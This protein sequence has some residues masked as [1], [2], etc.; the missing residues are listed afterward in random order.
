MA[1]W[2]PAWVTRLI[3]SPDSDSGS[4]KGFG[5]F[6]ILS[7]AP[8]LTCLSSFALFSWLPPPPCLPIFVA[9]CFSPQTT[10][11]ISNYYSFF[12]GLKTTQPTLI[13]WVVSFLES[14]F[15]LFIPARK[16]FPNLIR[17]DYRVGLVPWFGFDDLSF[18]NLAFPYLTQGQGSLRPHEFTGGLAGGTIPKGIFPKTQFM[19]PSH[20]VHS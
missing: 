13:K 18:N 5:D 17:D 12:E 6:P 2:L 19:A 1:P 3:P 7:S 11:T 10:T 4:T 8:S 20:Y 16:R 15:L 9:C 14:F